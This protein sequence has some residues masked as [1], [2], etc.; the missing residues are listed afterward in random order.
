MNEKQNF[1]GNRLEAYRALSLSL[2][3]VG[4]GIELL[5][6]IKDWVKSLGIVTFCS[7]LR[8]GM[9]NWGAEM[10]PKGLTLL[11]PSIALLIALLT[12]VTSFWMDVL[13]LPRVVWRKLEI[14]EKI[15]DKEGEE[16]KR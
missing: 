8:E 2:I 11:I 14:Y 5:R 3:W 1:V 13:M 9:L 15:S 12:E 7:E 4:E 16:A 10:F 6:L